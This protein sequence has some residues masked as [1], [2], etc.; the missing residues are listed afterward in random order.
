VGSYGAPQRGPICKKGERRRW[1]AVAAGSD[2]NER[3]GKAT[4]VLEEIL[5]DAALGKEAGGRVFFC[6]GKVMRGAVVTKGMVRGKWE[7]TEWDGNRCH[8]RGRIIV[9]VLKGRTFERRGAKVGERCE[10]GSGV[11]SE[12]LDKG[13]LRGSHL[14]RREVP[15]TGVPYKIITEIDEATKKRSRKKSRTVHRTK[16]EG[17]SLFLLG[18]KT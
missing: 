9:K 12:T 2:V 7:R 15:N 11:A 6:R 14:D 13:V 16:R 8:E 1:E 10:R 4:G 3:G 17:D 5:K 18:G